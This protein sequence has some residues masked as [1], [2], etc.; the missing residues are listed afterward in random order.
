MIVDFRTI[1]YCA[2]CGSFG[3]SD[4]PQSFFPDADAKNDLEKNLNVCYDLS[5]KQS[6]HQTMEC[7]YTEKNS[8]PRFYAGR[9]T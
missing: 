8:E 1:Q 7:W 4:H 5:R 9:T 6:E 2:F 3:I